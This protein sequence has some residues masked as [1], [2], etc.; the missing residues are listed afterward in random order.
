MH[1]TY[2][3]QKNAATFKLHQGLFPLKNKAQIKGKLAASTSSI[4]TTGRSI[5]FSN[6]PKKY[7][8]A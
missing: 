8:A 6:S 5:I 3:V 1:D 4:A 2:G 7:Q